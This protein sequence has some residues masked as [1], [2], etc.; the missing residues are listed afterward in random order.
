VILPYAR[1]PRPCRAHAVLLIVSV[2]APTLGINRT[3]HQDL[4]ALLQPGP[5]QLLND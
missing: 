2:L 1:I 5:I 3:S 4:L